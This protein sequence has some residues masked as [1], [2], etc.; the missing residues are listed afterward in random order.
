MPGHTRI[1]DTFF[2]MHPI[3]LKY[4]RFFFTYQLTQTHLR[5]LPDLNYDLCD[6]FAFSFLLL[7]IRFCNLGLQHDRKHEICS[8]NWATYV[9]F[10][11]IRS[12][13]C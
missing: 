5:T 10:Y 9:F 1:A 2:I 11:D 13:L 6:F 4:A 8:F 12:Q 7:H 3:T